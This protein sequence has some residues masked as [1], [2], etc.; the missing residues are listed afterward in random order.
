[1]KW[2]TRHNTFT[3][4]LEKS[5]LSLSEKASLMFLFLILPTLLGLLLVTILRIIEGVMANYF[6]LT[7]Q[8]ALILG[9]MALTINLIFYLKAFFG[10][11]L[12][13]RYV[14]PYWF[15]KVLCPAFFSCLLAPIAYIPVGSK[16]IGLILEVPQTS[17]LHYYQHNFGPGNPDGVFDTTVILSFVISWAMVLGVR[18]LGDI[19]RSHE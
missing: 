14:Q 16:L 1:L 6:L 8:L 7:W 3:K 18:K 13:H 19:V 17:T 5:W 15:R 9:A 12:A 10:K 2:T 11:S 4:S